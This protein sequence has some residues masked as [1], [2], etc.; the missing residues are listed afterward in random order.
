MDRPSSESLSGDL[1][2]RDLEVPPPSTAPLNLRHVRGV[3]LGATRCRIERKPGGKGFSMTFNVSEARV[4][5]RPPSVALLRC[6]ASD[7][8]GSTLSEPDRPARR[9]LCVA[10]VAEMIGCSPKAVRHR[11]ARGQLPGVTRIG[12]SVYLRRGAVLR[13]LAEGRGSSPK[14]SR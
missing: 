8:A 7:A 9:L 13:F 4:T 3:R 1:R 5:S 14:R 11:I 12:G 6:S 2:E 10:D